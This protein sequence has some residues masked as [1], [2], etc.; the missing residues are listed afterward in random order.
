MRSTHREPL[1]L[2]SD[3]LV[4]INELVDIVARIAGKVIHRTHDL[5]KPQGVRGRNSDNARLR[6]VLQWE[7]P[8]GLDEGLD[9][10]Y[11]WI[12]NRLEI[13]G[14]VPKRVGR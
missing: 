5:S 8:T 14:R 6:S 4:T 10:T 2:G 12:H 11:A 1:N 9:Q 7:P 3:R 13:D